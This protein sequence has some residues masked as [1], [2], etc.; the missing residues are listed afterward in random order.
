MF[1]VGVLALGVVDLG[2]PGMLFEGEVTMLEA[3][4]DEAPLRYPL[5][6][7]VAQDMVEALPDKSLFPVAG[8]IICEN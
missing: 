8:S 1:M 2:V 6:L 7:E 3:C 5:V 4:P